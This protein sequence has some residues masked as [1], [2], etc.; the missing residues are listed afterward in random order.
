MNTRTCPRLLA[1]DLMERSPCQVKMAAVLT[2]MNGRI[3]SWG[4]NSIGMDGFGLHAEQHAIQRANR[5][6]LRGSTISVA[7]RRKGWVLSY[8]CATCLDRIRASR[9]VRIEWLDKNGKWNHENL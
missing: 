4:W 3:F 5:N 2:D 1:I 8:P 6:R 7:G 9:V